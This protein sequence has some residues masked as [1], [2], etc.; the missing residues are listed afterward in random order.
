MK[1]DFSRDTFDKEKH[2]NG[3]LMQQ[4]RVQ[5]DAD[6]NEQRAIDR[7]RTETQGGD[8]IGH[9][10]APRESAGFE[11]TC[12]DGKTIQIGQGR[13]YVDGILCQNEKVVDYGA[14]P[15]LY[16]SPNILETLKEAIVGLVYLDVWQRH[17]TPLDDSHIR[18]KALGGPDT[19]TRIKTIW[20]VKVLPLPKLKIKKVSDLADLIKKRKEIVEKLREVLAAGKEDAAEELRRKLAEVEQVI[21]ELTPNLSCGMTLDEW[22]NLAELSTGTLKAHTA[23]SSTQST[24]CKLPPLAGYQRLENQLYRVEVHVGGRRSKATF[25]WSRDNGSVVT[26]V[27]KISGTKVTVADVGKDEVLGFANDQWVEI[28][29]DATELS[30]KPGQLI[31]IAD[32]DP[33]KKEIT[34]KAAPTS[35]DMGLHPKLRRWDQSGTDAT[36]TGVEMKA[37]WIELEDGIEVQFSNGRYETGDYWLIPGRTATGEIEWPGLNTVGEIEWPPYESTATEPISRPPLGIQHHFCRLALI[38]YNDQ[39][40]KLYVLDDCRNLFPAVTQ[41]TSLFYVSGDGQEALPGK[42]LAQP[43][44]VGVANGHWPVEGARVQFQVITGDGDLGGTG[45]TYLAC[46]GPDGIASCSWTLNNKTASQQVQAILLGPAGKRSHLPIRFTANLSTA[47]RVAYN[48]KKCPKL[49]EAGADTV[50]EAI[51]LLCQQAGGGADPGIHIKDVRTLY[52]DQRL[53]NDG[54]VSV[55]VLAQGLCAVCDAPV[56]PSTISRPTCFVTL[57][58]PF[59]RQVKGEMEAEVAL[60]GYHPFVLAAV[61]SAKAEKVIWKPTNDA[62]QWL[63][64]TLFEKATGEEDQRI[65]ARLTLK[66]NFIWEQADNAP[67]YLDGDVL[68]DRQGDRSNSLDLPSGDGVQGGDFEMWFWITP[69]SQIGHIG[70]ID[71]NIATRAELEMLPGVGEAMANRIV[72]NRPYTTVAELA[73]KVSGIGPSTL[74]KIEPYIVV[75]ES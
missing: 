59:T 60:I 30:G 70:T 28:S 20:Q 42:Q 35:V 29:D 48:S 14:Q 32:V 12:A 67:R 74:K 13:Y 36:A 26:T 18:E 71:I 24:P 40:R 52:P 68:G 73:A 44:Q 54:L 37:G 2:Y 4:G 31:Q 16:A 61:V 33:D 64:D 17:I 11:I 51:D 1:G 47:D 39:D 56:E 46:T 8:V 49:S 34:L 50:Q 69:P 75:T 6:W 41:L 45:K 55:S 10:G 23:P 53:R 3:V 38:F 19:A 25:K 62:M 22:T 5:V 43:L 72:A 7:Y 57:E 63:Q 58:L 66:G 9:C 65:L 27:K 21:V 15:D